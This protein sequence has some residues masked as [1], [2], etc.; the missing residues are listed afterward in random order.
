MLIHHPEAFESF[1]LHVVPMWA[2]FS[3]RWNW[4]E[5]LFSS[6]SSSRLPST[7]QIVYLGFTKVYLP[8]VLFYGTFLS[9]QPYLPYVNDMETLFDWYAYGGKPDVR[10][11][12]WHLW[13]IKRITAETTHAGVG[14]SVVAA[15]VSVLSLALND[16][17]APFLAPSVWAYCSIHG[18]M[19]TQGL[20]AAALSFRSQRVHMVWIICVIIG[21]M[22]T[23]ISF[24]KASLVDNMEVNP[25][26]KLLTGFRDCGIAW[27]CVLCAYLYDNNVAKK[28]SQKI[29]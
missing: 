25:E 3:L 15:M 22:S 10:D 9:L 1:F 29:N 5:T 18:I 6:S 19:A 17:I 13:L 24:Y 23:G 16:N 21:C 7:L 4:G 12:P 11:D 8:W 27:I 28:A 2:S 14:K 26:N 20:L